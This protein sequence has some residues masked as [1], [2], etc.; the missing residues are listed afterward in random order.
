MIKFN[1]IKAIN[2]AFRSLVSFFFWCFHVD[3]D[4][5]L[6]RSRAATSGIWNFS[7][8]TFM[9]KYDMNKW[10]VRRPVRGSNSE[11]ILSALPFSVSFQFG[12]RKISW[13]SLCY[14]MWCGDINQKRSKKHNSKT[15]NRLGEVKGNVCC[16]FFFSSVLCRHQRHI[17]WSETDTLL[18]TS[19]WRRAWQEEKLM[20]TPLKRQPRP[21]N[22]GTDSQRFHQIEIM[23]KFLG[24]HPT[25]LWILLLSLL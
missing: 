6:A 20:S 15:E 9:C 7:D 17:M 23:N 10:N 16:I 18:T 1:L 21:V 4:D 8:L 3:C 22:D 11:Q 12:R 19:C 24:C 5:S 2:F 14:A 25:F 13:F